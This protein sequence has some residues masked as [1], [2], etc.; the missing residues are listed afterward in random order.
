MTLR[1]VVLTEDPGGPSARHRWTYPAAGLR[2]EGV[3]VSLH[4]LE[5]RP[6]RPE[7]FAAAAAA[8]A[9]VVH[10]K[11]LRLPDLRRL[12]RSARR[13]FAYDLDDAVMYRP[14]GRRR[15]WSVLRALRFSRMVR[16]SRLYIAG[17]PY[18]AER[19]PRLVPVLLRPTPVDLPRY[20]GR[21]PHEG[22]GRVLGW[23]GTS[24]TAPFLAALAGPLAALTAKRPGLSLRVVGPPP[25]SLPGVAVEWRAWSE[26]SE[27]E[28]LRG[29]DVGLMPMPDDRFTRG[30]CAFKA[31]QCMACGVPVVASPVGMN[32]EA[33][34]DGE[35]GFLAADRGEWE[36]RIARLLD[37]PALRNSFG[38]AGR[39]RVAERF[40]NDVLT[41]RLADALKRVF[42]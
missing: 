15:Q 30:K 6:A 4:A 10:R 35:T 33:V 14:P 42:A 36:G 17:N 23:I 21:R 40:C 29:F 18:L 38:A 5:P 11:L 2:R 3:E 34:V 16:L 20:A 27:A 13:G 31:L 37:D 9:V 7:A 32:A 25:P 28:A 39:R 26:E 24:A 19:A 1:V 12:G 8:D 22:P 41:P